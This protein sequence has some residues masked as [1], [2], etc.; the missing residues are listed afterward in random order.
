[1]PAQTRPQFVAL[2][3]FA[4]L[5]AGCAR[6]DAPA[7]AGGSRDNTLPVYTHTVEAA[8]LEEV[9]TATGT[10]LADEAVQLTSEVAGLVTKVNF[11][12]GTRVSAGDLL[13]Q[14]NDAELRAELERAKASVSL[15]RIQ[16]ERQKKLLNVQGASQEAYDLALNELKVLEADAALIDARLAKTGVK[17]PFDGRIGLRHISEGAY[18]SPGSP[19]AT[20]QKLD[21][22]KIEFSVAERHMDRLRD[23]AEVEV[24]VAGVAE[25]LTATVYAIEPRIDEST[26]T[27]RLRAR[28]DNPEGRVLPGAFATVRVPLRTIPDALL[29]PAAAIIPG[30]N[31]QTVYVVEDGKAAPRT[32][33]TGVRLDRDVQITSGLKAGDVVITSGQLQVRPGAAVR[34]ANRERKADEQ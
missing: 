26:R 24:R 8:P 2:A 34:P 11:D 20:L 31:Q 32:V 30:L 9:V 33:Q 5:A 15:A 23:G 16:A 4:A 18:L 25:P 13:F 7:S 12:E 28:A 21:T 6:D 17:A 3:L 1:M 29:V 10:V 14:T 19:V 22:L 27:I